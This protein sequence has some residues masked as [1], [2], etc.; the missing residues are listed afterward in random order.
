[1]R[2]ALHHH[3]YDSGW[4]NTYHTFNFAD[5]QGP[6]EGY[7]TLRVINEDR[8]QGGEG[9]GT[10]PHRIYE[11][12]SYVLGGRLEHKDSLGNIEVLKRGDVQFTTTGTGLSHSEYNHSKTEPVHFLQMW[13]LPSDPKLP[14]G[15]QTKSFSDEEKRNQL[16]LIVG[17]PHKDESAVH[18][19]QDCSVYASL[20]DAGKTV[21]HKFGAGRGGYLH[22]AMVNDGKVAVNGIELKAGD[23]AFI[24]QTEEIAIEGRSEEGKGPAEFVLFD[25]N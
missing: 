5:Y 4:L 7:R 17:G 10:H 24:E 15:Y 22:L 9:F 14:P 13:V 6:F 23:G 3:L 16:R 12:F 20:L 8:V 21:R 25:L 19:H 11:I 1:M 18:I 2:D